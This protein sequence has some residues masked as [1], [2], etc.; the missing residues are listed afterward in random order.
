MEDGL[1]SEESS[2]VSA[3]SRIDRDLDA[4]PFLL[5]VGV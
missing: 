2:L 1:G 5:S 3:E 4:I